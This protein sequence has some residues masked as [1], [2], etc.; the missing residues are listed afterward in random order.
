MKLCILGDTHFGMRSDSIAFMDYAEKFYSKIFFPYL[1]ENKIDTIIQLGDFF[2]RR[3]YV[4]FLTL[5][6]CKEMFIDKLVEHKIHMHVLIGNHDSF[7]KNT[8]EVNSI[9]LMLGA[10]DNISIVTEPITHVMKNADHH[11]PICLIPWINEGNYEDSMAQLHNSPASICMGHFEIAGFSMYKGMP[12]EDGLDRNKFNRFSLVLS[13]HFHHSSSQGNITYVGTPMQITW[14]DYKDPKGFFTLDTVTLD[15]EFIE[16]TFEMFHQIRYDDKL[17]SIT[18][19]NGKDLSVYTNTYVKVVVINKTN[20]YLFDKFMNNLYNVN[21]VDV[22]IAED[23]TEITDIID[24][25]ALDQAEDTLTIIN[26]FVDASSNEGIENGRLKAVMRE[27][28][29]EALNRDNL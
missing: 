8:N 10:H 29:N 16:N 23:F 21:P 12:S 9:D 6:R 19:I 17:E 13:G 2:D 3:K 20:P 1:V 24:T 26:K 4:N 5:K 18:E 28:Y 11:L 22:T 7:Y 15:M 27:L 25:E 14:Q